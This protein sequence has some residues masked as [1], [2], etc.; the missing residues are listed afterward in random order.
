VQEAVA[1][2]MFVSKRVLLIL[3]ITEAMDTL[4]FRDRSGTS[5]ACYEGT[6]RARRKNNQRTRIVTLFE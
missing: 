1:R 4:R 5:F 3:E 6:W 2:L